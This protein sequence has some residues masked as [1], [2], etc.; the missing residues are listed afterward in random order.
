MHLNIQSITNKTQALQHLAE[1]HN[2]NVICLSEHWLNKGNETVYNLKGYNWCSKYLRQRHIHGGTAILCRNDTPAHPVDSITNMSEELHFEAAAA[3]LPEQN[4]LV[5]SVYRSGLG[6]FQQ[7]LTLLERALSY[8]MTTYP[9]DINIVVCGDFNVQLMNNCDRAQQ[10]IN[11]MEMFNLHQTIFH[12][13]RNNER[14][15]IFLPTPINLSS[16]R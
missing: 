3:H 13:T 10:L 7:F 9:P 5:I 11:T 6:D 4:L 1:S 2:L 15:I 16:N 14:L 12:P 8:A